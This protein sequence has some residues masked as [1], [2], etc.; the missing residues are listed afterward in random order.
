[1]DFENVRLGVVTAIDRKKA[2]A[3]VRFEEQ[4]DTTSHELA[5]MQKNTFK[6]KSYWMPDVDEQVICLFLNN[7]QETGVIIGSIY[8][9][10]EEALHK[11]VPEISD[12]G[13][14]RNGTW[15]EDGS[16]VKYEHDTQTLVVSGIKNIVI[17]AADTVSISDKRGALL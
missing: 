10:D 4:D 11:P 17:T 14:H 8:S 6:S 9:E 7:G 15:L 12:D 13:K 3:R 5:V 1:M 2:R 16:F